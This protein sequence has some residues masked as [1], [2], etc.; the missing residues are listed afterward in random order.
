MKVTKDKTENSQAYLTIEM[1]PEETEK[2]VESAY[3]R[4]VKSARVPGFRKGKAP[5]EIFE[6]YVGKASLL[7]EALN[8]MV[9]QAYEDAIKE[10]ELEAIAQP[11]I[12]V[13]KME[14]VTFTA[15]V[16]LKPAIELG[17]YYTIK[18]QPDKAEITES[19][20]DD[21]IEHLRHQYATWEPVERAVELND[22]VA[23]DVE[24]S[25][26]GETYIN[27]KGAQYQVT[28]EQV[29]PAPGFSEQLV[30]MTK[31]QEK[32]FKLTLPEENM[33]EKYAGK[34]VSFKITLNEIKQE[35]LPEMND[36][37][38]QGVDAEFK[39][40]EALKERT[41]SDLTKRAEER[42]K[43]DFEE[44]VIDAVVDIS[45]LEYPPVLVHAEIH[46][47]V[48]QRFQG[49]Q[50]E[51]E[52]YL[53]SVNKTS[54]ELHEELEPIAEKS[55][56]RSL[57]LGKVIET[58]NITVD[59]VEIDKEIDEITK[60]SGENKESII[61]VLNT[62]DARGSIKQRLITRKAV[63]YLTEIAVNSKK[64]KKK[65]EKVEKPELEKEDE[66]E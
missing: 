1:D 26:D 66:N 5:R 18:L 40:M 32:E 52:K 20:V 13:T 42:V 56:R 6:R 41:L 60:D 48:D 33:E 58:E 47:I 63:L 27:Q 7:E 17:D 10:Q 30:G 25:V 44:K 21:V 22:M 2:S 43:A 38:A 64:K 36:A 46:R 45:K 57:V 11:E 23:F 3:K 50:Q 8:S 49:N 59:D 35:M 15:V 61:K 54:E 34:E 14:P 28:A 62:P 9:P 39:T 19:N 4:M 37:F 31:G 12:E 65:T 53:M 16:P 55:V 24:S 51:V 29:F